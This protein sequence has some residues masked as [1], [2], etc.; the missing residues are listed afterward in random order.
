M[1]Q[2]KNAPPEWRARDNERRRQQRAARK[3]DREERARARALEAVADFLA[4]VRDPEA[5]G[6]EG[7][8]ALTPEDLREIAA[9]PRIFDPD[10]PKIMA[11]HQM[12][13]W[14]AA[15]HRTKTLAQSP[16]VCRLFD[17]LRFAM[18]GH[19]ASD[20]RPSEP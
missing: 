1:D 4:E 11:G 5:R 17:R 6:R 7:N 20:G 2:S 8:G 12:K 3:K 14:T 16:A 9:R 13:D 10:V 18:H 19:T 15:T